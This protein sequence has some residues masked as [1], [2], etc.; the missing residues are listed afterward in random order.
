MGKTNDAH[1]AKLNT[2]G[3]A[4]EDMNEEQRLALRKE[5]DKIVSDP[6][7]LYCTCPR[8]GCRNNHN[9]VFCVALHRYYDGFPDCLRPLDEKMQE[10]IP[11]NRR[12]NMHLKI[13]S[14]GTPEGI[15]DPHDPDGSRERLFKHAQEANVKDQGVAAADRWHKIVKNPKNRT[16]TCS[17]TDCWYHGNCVKCIALH[18]HFDGFP[19]CDRYIV[20]KIDDIVDTYWAEQSGK[21]E[22]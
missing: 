15:I 17:H 12:Y 18:R 1:L 8:T 22:N 14:D 20:D 9:C 5:W 7:E 6:D 21:P 3:I 2:T 4:W 19:A 11:Q 10:G 16:C 13:Q